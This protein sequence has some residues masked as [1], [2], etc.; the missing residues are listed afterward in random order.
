MKK[1]PHSRYSRTAARRWSARV[2][3]TSDAMTLETGIFR[4]NDPR[5]IARSVKR[6]SEHSHRRKANPYRS[7]ISM[8]TFYE[9]RA[10]RNLSPAKKLTLEE[11]KA[12]LKKL[13]GK[14]GYTL[15]RKKKKE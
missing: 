2:T 15:R 11:A 3:D 10:G 5:R 4:S 6:S 8:L 1:N 7:A 14:S 12:E 13:F 9:N